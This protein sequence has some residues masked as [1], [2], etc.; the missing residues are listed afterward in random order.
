MDTSTRVL[1]AGCNI[2]PVWAQRTS[3]GMSQDGEAKAAP[4]DDRGGG[5]GGGETNPL[6]CSVAGTAVLM[7]SVT[8]FLQG[9]KRGRAQSQQLL[10][11]AEGK[12]RMLC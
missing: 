5:G 1:D 10:P 2:V 12:S 4:D 11:L 8:K 9:S 6:H 3:R 7:K